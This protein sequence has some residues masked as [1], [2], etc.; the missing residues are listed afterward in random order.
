M[1]LFAE[2]IEDLYTGIVSDYVRKTPALWEE[3]A[4]RLPSGEMYLVDPDPRAPT[5]AIPT[6][7]NLCI[8]IHNNLQFSARL[9][10]WALERKLE[11]THENFVPGSFAEY[12][13]CELKQYIESRKEI[14]DDFYKHLVINTQTRTF[15]DPNYVNS[16]GSKVVLKPLSET[17]E[18]SV[19]RDQQ[20]QRTM[21]HH[22]VRYL[23]KHHNLEL[24]TY[25]QVRCQ[26]QLNL[27]LETYHQVRYQ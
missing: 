15:E 7:T 22:Q 27:L 17:L 14:Q 1:S 21:T 26:F 20:L 25:D 16:I 8:D 24:R 9:C 11:E 13:F 6:E 3:F 18:L 5:P 12:V 10:Y 19:K 4:Q 2:A 23:K